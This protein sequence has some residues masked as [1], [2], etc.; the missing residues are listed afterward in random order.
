MRSYK[1]EIYFTIVGSFFGLVLLLIILFEIFYDFSIHQEIKKARFVSDVIL[2]FR[3]Y[4]AKVSPCIKNKCRNN[5]FVCSPAYVTNEVAKIIKIKNHFLIRQ[6]SDNYRN[7]EDKPN[8]LELKA[9]DY[10]KKH[11][12]KNEFIKI[13]NLSTNNKFLKKSIFYARALRIKESCL[14]CHGVPYRDVPK[15]LYK[16]LL[17][18][19]GNRAFNYKLGDVRGIIA[20]YIPFE[21]V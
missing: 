21:E 7:I 13:S 17:K 3:D 8:L 20:L 10:F 9:I 14:K 6:V 4:L 15:D 5:P 11:L 2:D 1:K 18:D 19:Y 12:N 16:L